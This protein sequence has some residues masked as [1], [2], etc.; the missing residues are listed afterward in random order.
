[1]KMRAG[2]VETVMFELNTDSEKV[3][4]F[5][6]DYS[7]KIDYIELATILRLFD[8]ARHSR[9]EQEGNG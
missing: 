8:C 3:T 6:G 5:V 1:M 4:V 7:A 9:D 2:Y